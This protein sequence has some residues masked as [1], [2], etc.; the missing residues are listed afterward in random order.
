MLNEAVLSSHGS[1]FLFT[2]ITCRGYLA[3]IRYY[4]AYQFAIRYTRIPKKVKKW[5]YNNQIM[6]CQFKLSNWTVAKLIS[7]NVSSH[8]I[9]RWVWIEGKFADWL[10][11]AHKVVWRTILS[12][13]NRIR[14]NHNVSLLIKLLCKN[15]A[16]RQFKI[17]HCGTP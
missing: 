1:S 12:T 13:R 14:Y 8:N 16:Y 17:F 6:G 9:I 2:W 3:Q 15:K 5:F 4:H 7:C 10:H 11:Y